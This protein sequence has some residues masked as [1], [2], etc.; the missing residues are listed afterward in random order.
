MLHSSAMDGPEL[1]KLLLEKRNLTPNALADILRKRTLQSQMQRYLARETKNPRPDTLAPIARY[2]G[3]GVEAFY[4]PTIARQIAI[5][6]GLTRA[7]TESPGHHV[8]EPSA[9]WAAAPTPLRPRH[10]QSVRELVTLLGRALE[11]YDESAR[12]A[13]ATLLHDVAMHPERAA[14]T[15]E[16]IGALLDVQGNDPPHKSSNS[17]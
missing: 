15:G 13:V 11:D 8:A 2:F 14:L 3:I 1:L 7:Q 4:Q 17:M 5:E 6:Q 12:K 10:R 9:A 16:R